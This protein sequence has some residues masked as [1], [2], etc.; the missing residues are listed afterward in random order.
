M[1]NGSPLAEKDKC[2]LRYITSRYNCIKLA[3]AIVKKG[4]YLTDAGGDH[5]LSVHV[6]NGDFSNYA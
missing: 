6:I 1:K 5:P 4:K 3:G 2:L